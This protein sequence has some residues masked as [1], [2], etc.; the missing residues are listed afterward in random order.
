MQKISEKGVLYLKRVRLSYIKAAS[1]A[2][3]EGYVGTTLEIFKSNTSNVLL[4][5]Q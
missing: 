2:G 5:L 4:G 3:A 1:N